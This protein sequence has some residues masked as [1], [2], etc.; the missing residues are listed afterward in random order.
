MSLNQNG[1]GPFK[2][3]PVRK[4]PGLKKGLRTW[5]DK[6]NPK[7]IGLGKSTEMRHN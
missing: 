2:A 1:L 3:K 6:S 5:G 7:G 4:N